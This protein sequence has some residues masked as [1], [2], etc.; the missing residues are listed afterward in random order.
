MDALINVK[1]AEV[2]KM[3]LSYHSILQRLKI[4]NDSAGRFNCKK[5]GGR[6]YIYTTEINRNHNRILSESQKK[7]LKDKK[8]KGE[9]TPR[10]R[11]K[12]IQTLQNWY[13]TA[14]ALNEQHEAVGIKGR[15]KVI[16]L[17]LTLS[18]AQ[19]HDD[20][21]IKRHLF[22]HFMA[23]ILKKKPETNYL[24]KAE[25]QKNGNLHFHIFLD[26]Y[27]DKAWIQK[28]WNHVQSLHNYHPCIDLDSNDL[29]APSTRIEALYSKNDAMAYAAK[30][31]AKEE[32]E[33]KISGRVWGCSKS[34]KAL[35][36]VIYKVTLS[37]IEKHFG[38]IVTE[39]S[40][41]VGFEKCFIITK[42]HNFNELSKSIENR[43]RVKLTKLQ[44]IAA[45]YFGGRDFIEELET[46]DFMQPLPPLELKMFT[47]FIDILNKRKN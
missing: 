30:Y 32:G 18:S 11:K 6:V 14:T 9:V 37:D 7:V 22:N 5:V 15:R 13:D 19:K 25:K 44:N 12:I 45:L 43:G 33:Q 39:N 36:P 31:V 40:K 42:A 16:L 20:K 1:V 10:I 26:N 4:Y 29:G 27:F 34:L 3:G 23:Y 35:K 8:Y 24:W 41:I 2:A 28:T 17:T 47:S 46:V 21:Y 38:D